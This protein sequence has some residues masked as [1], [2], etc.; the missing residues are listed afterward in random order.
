MYIK[1]L[2]E[3]KI[4]HKLKLVGGVLLEGSRDVGKT[5]TANKICKSMIKLDTE[6]IERIEIDSSLLTEGEKPRLIDE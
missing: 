4:L 1:R 3:E 5:E 6:H 2:I